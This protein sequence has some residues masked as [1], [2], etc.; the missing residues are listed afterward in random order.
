VRAYRSKKAILTETGLEFDAGWWW[1]PAV[2][3]LSQRE[4]RIA[5]IQPQLRHDMVLRARNAGGACGAGPGRSLCGCVW[6][7]EVAARHGRGRAQ[8]FQTSWQRRCDWCGFGRTTAVSAVEGGVEA[9]N[10]FSDG[11]PSLV[12]G[13][14]SLDDSTEAASQRHPA[15]TMAFSAKY[16][17]GVSGEVRP[18]CPMTK[19]ASRRLSPQT[20]AWRGFSWSS[21]VYAAQF[22]M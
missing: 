18:C 20:L 8:W 19:T 17:A 22:S 4:L 21:P 15:V 9:L 11:Y 10:Q 12:L 7:D 1:T 5:L 3:F 6:G 13:Q 2:T 14:P 16:R